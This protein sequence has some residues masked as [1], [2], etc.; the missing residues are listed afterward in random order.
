MKK[1]KNNG[2]KNRKPLTLR[3]RIDIELQYRYG[4]SINSI[5]N[6]VERNKSTI[7]REINGRPRR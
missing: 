6:K 1:K 4:A 5:A 3:E 7:S 2:P